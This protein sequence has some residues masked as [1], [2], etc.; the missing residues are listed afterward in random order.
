M[1]RFILYL[2]CGLVLCEIGECFGSVLWVIQPTYTNVA[3]TAEKTAYLFGVVVVV[4][5]GCRR[6]RIF[7]HGAESTLLLD[8]GGKVV[9]SQTVPEH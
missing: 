1:I 4:N 6:E 7:A 3:A 9:K 8:Q 2:L 5:V